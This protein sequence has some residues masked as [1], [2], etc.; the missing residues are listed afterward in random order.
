MK[1]CSNCK[2]GKDKSD[3]RIRTDKRVNPVLVYLNN[4][5]KQ[6]ETDKANEYY[7]KNGQ[8]IWFKEKNRKRVNE[9]AQKNKSAVLLRERIRKQTQKWK[10]Y[11]R[12]YNAKNRERIRE[13]SRERNR[14]YMKKLITER[15]YRYA[16]LKLKDETGLKEEMIPPELIE[17][18]NNLLQ[19]Q[20]KLKN[21]RKYA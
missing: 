2:I 7:S 14:K 5:C 19:L 18:K 10:E 4:I 15:P 21:P 3:F 11:M 12:E 8:T 17:A 20:R 1:V 9:Y 13:M 6:C 16:M